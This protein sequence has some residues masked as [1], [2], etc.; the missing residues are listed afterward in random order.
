MATVTDPATT[1]K[2]KAYF[3]HYLGLSGAIVKPADHVLFIDAESGA[4]VRLTEADYA[5]L[6]VLGEVGNSALQHLEDRLRGGSVAIA[7][8]RRLEVQ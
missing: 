8:T 2:P 1:R 7:C 4:A 6:T 3:A 5:N